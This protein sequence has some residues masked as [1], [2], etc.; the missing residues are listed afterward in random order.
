MSKIVGTQY[1]SSFFCMNLIILMRG[2]I[3]LELIDETEIYTST[4]ELP[5][6]YLILKLR[7]SFNKD[8]YEKKIISFDVYNRMQILLTKKMDKIILKYRN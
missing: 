1:L 3:I 2:G 5:K 4:K 7:M 6:E 8:L